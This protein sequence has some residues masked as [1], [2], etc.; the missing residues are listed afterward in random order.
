MPSEGQPSSLHIITTLEALK[1]FSDP[2][3]QQIIEAL[4]DGAKTVKQVA[5][6]LELA[7]TKLYYHVNLLEEHGLIQVTETRIVSGIIEKHYMAAA[8]EYAI[9]RSLMTPGQT[10]GDEGLEIVFDAMIE[11]IR[12]DLHR[13]LE[14][15]LIDTSANAPEHRKFRMWRGMSQLPNDRA[16]EFYQRLEALVEE[17][18]EVSDEESDQGYGLL[19]GIYP[20]TS[21]KKTFMP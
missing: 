3:R 11:P 18:N 19:L 20:A 8:L 9:E 14:L 6:E 7:P 17:F 4:L 13:S 15:G 5:A 12:A 1:V 21:P 10:M 16:I 2:L